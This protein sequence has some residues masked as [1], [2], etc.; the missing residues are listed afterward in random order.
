MFKKSFKL[1]IFFFVFIF[2]VLSGWC[3]EPIHLVILHVND[4]HGKLLSY[5]TESSKDIGG[6]ARIA[7]EIKEIRAENKNTLVFHAGDDLSRGDMITSCFGGEANMLAMESAG[8]DAYTPGNGDFYFGVNNLIKQT[9]LVKFPTLMANIVY[10]KDDKLIFQPY[11][12]KEIGGIRVA[13][14][15][16]GYIHEEHPSSKLLKLLDPITVAKKYVPILQEKSDIIIALT[17]I[18]IGADFLLAGKVPEIDVIVGGHTHTLLEKPMMIPRLKG[19][20][21]VVIVQAG[22]LGQYLGRLDLDIKVNESGK[23]RVVKADETLIPINNK[24]KDDEDITQILKPY[25]DK[26][27]EVLFTSKA[28]ITKKEMGNLTA[29]AVRTQ[30]GSDIA[31]L[32]I[33]SIQSGLKE[34]DVTLE[35]IYEIHPWRNRVLMF[36]LTGEQIQRALSE[37]DAI[38]S[39]FSYTKSNGKVDNLNI[40]KSH[41]EPTKTYKVAMDEFLWAYIPS[42]SN[43]SFSDTGERVDTILIKYFGNMKKGL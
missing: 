10:K 43:V 12:I 7:T 20:G 21:S 23:Y 38:V 13:I 41:I 18:G 15:G 27:S 19:K 36:E 29:E 17:H 31:M 1:S 2:A 32:D 39:G 4:T 28:T 35:K 37:K 9:S 5:D 3:G 11:V 25:K 14:L 40:G 24:I 8:Y 26:L 22:E 16:L 33:G 34:G 30:T 42:L 6:I